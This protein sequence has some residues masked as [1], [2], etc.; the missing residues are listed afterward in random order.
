[1][2]V[3]LATRRG[4]RSWDIVTSQQDNYLRSLRLKTIW[5]S[6]LALKAFCEQ[7]SFDDTHALLCQCGI[8]SFKPDVRDIIPVT[9]DGTIFGSVVIWGKVIECEY[10]YRSEYAYPVSLAGFCCLVCK[11]FSYSDTQLAFS[12]NDIN[13]DQYKVYKAICNTCASLATVKAQ[14][15]YIPLPANLLLKDL[16]EFYNLR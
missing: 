3:Y 10:G 6:N 4:N 9:N 2:T 5:P 16:R 13:I 14:F 8:Y 1:M 7:G 15:R 12:R 11:R